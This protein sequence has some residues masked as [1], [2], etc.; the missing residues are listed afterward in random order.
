MVYGT[1]YADPAVVN[2]WQWVDG[3]RRDGVVRD[4]RHR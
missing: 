2:R 4:T 1:F 3:K